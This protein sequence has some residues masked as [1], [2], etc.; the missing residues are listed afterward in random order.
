MC[1][2]CQIAHHWS[3]CSW[4]RNVIACSA[5]SCWRA[6]NRCVGFFPN[7]APGNGLSWGR[8]R[9]DRGKA[10]ITTTLL[11][12]FSSR[13]V[14]HIVHYLWLIIT[15][16]DYLLWLVKTIHLH[17]IITLFELK[18]KPTLFFN[19]HFSMVVIY[20]YNLQW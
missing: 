7:L 4:Q 10:F 16:Y 2:G 12:A 15:H 19:D 17:A 3:T 8:S 18:E 13:S 6:E 9:L 5:A 14:I 20:F 11:A 1:S